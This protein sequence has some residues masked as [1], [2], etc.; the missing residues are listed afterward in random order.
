MHPLLIQIGSIPIHTY[1]F[2]VA[3]GFLIAVQV[4]KYLSI[5][6]KLD[7]E[8]VLDLAF[9]GLLVGFLGARLL[10]VITRYEDFV[11]QPLSIFKVWEGGLVFFWWS[12][13]G[14]SLCFVLCKK[15][16]N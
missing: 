4:F 7:V 10:F 9:W 6:S 2:L 16:I 11:S 8:K 12:N 15:N 3:M 1:G 5:R 14:I 13:R